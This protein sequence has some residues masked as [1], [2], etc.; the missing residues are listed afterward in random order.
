M[1]AAA[2]SFVAY[3]GRF[4]DVYRTALTRVSAAPPEAASN[5]GRSGRATIAVDPATNS[6]VIVG[7]EKEVERLAELA[8]HHG[9]ELVERLLLAFFRFQHVIDIFFRHTVAKQCPFHVVDGALLKRALAGIGNRLLD[10]PLTPLRSPGREDRQGLH[11]HARHG[12][13]PGGLADPS[14]QVSRCFQTGGEHAGIHC[15]D[16]LD[17]AIDGGSERSDGLGIDSAGNAQHDD[18]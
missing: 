11:A 12:V 7:S 15:V 5:E 6:L 13:G 14:R 10:A 4:I 9:A 3:Y 17:E 1:A 16:L 2:V 8:R 18:H